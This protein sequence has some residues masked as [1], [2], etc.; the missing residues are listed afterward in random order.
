MQLFP[1]WANSAGRVIPIVGIVALTGAVAMG[2]VLVRSPYQ[3]RQGEPREQPVPFSHQHHVGDIGIDC[4]Y[5]HTSVEESAFAGLPSTQI[6]MNC[7]NLLWK[8]SP[9]LAPVHESWNSK[10]PIRWLRVHD[11]PDY[12]YFD[13]S[14]HVVKGVGCVGMSWSN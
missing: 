4:R 9:M 13:H 2:M 10:I 6:C 5:C 1:Q 11:V 12:V 8:N 7:H 3:T 14:V